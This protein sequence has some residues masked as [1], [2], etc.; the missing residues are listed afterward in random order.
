M[1]SSRIRYVLMAIFAIYALICLFY[2]QYQ[3]AAFGG[4]LLAFLV[5][6]HYKQS[7]VLLASKYFKNG[8]FESAATALSE[9]PDPERLA[10][11]RRGYYEFM[12]ASIALKREEY[13]EAEYH[14]QLASLFPLGGKT[15]KTFV[16]IH[17]AN[18]ALRKKDK[19]RM[20]AYIEKAKEMAS[21]PKASDIINRLEKEANSL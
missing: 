1:Y 3:L 6:S 16:M 21:T 12:M 9:V 15:D 13:E 7:S 4:L 2:Q 20:L 11:N 14:F 19:E 17:L 5:W 18:L 10:K 8:E